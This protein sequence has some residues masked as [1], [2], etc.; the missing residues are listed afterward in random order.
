MNK[1]NKLK[2]SFASYWSDKKERVV[3]CDLDQLAAHL[4]ENW[5]NIPKTLSN[6]KAMEIHLL[7]VAY[8]KYRD[9]DKMKYPRKLK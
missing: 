3:K 8:L 6:H 5:G 9:K 2:N 7:A 4:S 1:K